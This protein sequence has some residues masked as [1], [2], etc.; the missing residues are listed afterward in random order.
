MHRDIEIAVLD[1]IR[2]YGNGHC[3][4]AGPLRESVNRLEKV[5]L[6]VNRERPWPV[7]PYCTRHDATTPIIIIPR[8]GVHHL[9]SH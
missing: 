6:I 5:D 1:G 4:P 7:R 9:I 2:R 8:K 3:L